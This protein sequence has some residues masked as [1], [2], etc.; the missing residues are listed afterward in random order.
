MGRKQDLGIKGESYVAKYLASNGYEIL[1]CNWRIR[2]GEIDLIAVSPDGRITFDNRVQ[3]LEELEKIFGRKVDLVVKKN[4]R[5]PF[6]RRAILTS[7]E[8]VYAA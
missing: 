3:M 1:D 2:E 8:I 4:L 5:N 6:R 7:R